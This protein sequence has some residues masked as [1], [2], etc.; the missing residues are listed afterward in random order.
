MSTADEWDF[1][2]P[3]D[4]GELLAELRRHGVRP[5]LRLHVGLSARRD[6][7]PRADE[8]PAFF[9]SFRSGQPDLAERSSEI[10]RAE[11]PDGR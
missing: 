4:D 3:D 11:F 9:A 6:E 2:V 8:L 1:T 5:G 10:L 7:S